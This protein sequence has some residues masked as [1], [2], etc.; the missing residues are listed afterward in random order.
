MVA[1]LFYS[2]V[3]TSN[4]IRRAGFACW[5]TCRHGCTSSICGIHTLDYWFV[6]FVQFL[7]YVNFFICFNQAVDKCDIFNW[8][9]L[10]LLEIFNS[11][12]VYESLHIYQL[13]GISNFIVGSFKK[14]FIEVRMS[15]CLS[16]WLT[17]ILKLNFSKG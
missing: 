6:D 13:Q 16:L 4:N 15:W 9:L 8:K 3:I 10:T 14:R 1:V 17:L 2:P 11:F 7:F 12:C 5:C